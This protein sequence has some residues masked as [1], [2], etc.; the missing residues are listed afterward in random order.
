MRRPLDSV[1]FFSCL[2]FH[3]MKP[4]TQSFPAFTR[5]LFWKAL[6]FGRRS[7]FSLKPFP[8]SFLPSLLLLSSSLPPFFPAQPRPPLSRTQSSIPHIPFSPLHLTTP[9]SRPR[10]ASLRRLLLRSMQCG[11]PGTRHVN[12][13]QR[14]CPVCLDRLVGPDLHWCANTNS[15][16]A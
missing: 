9:W 14:P 13:Y 1:P 6:F 7:M 5:F 12:L 2:S 3:G 11:H 4:A 8:T 15:L 10:E 16:A